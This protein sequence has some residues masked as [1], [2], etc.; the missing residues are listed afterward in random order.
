MNPI[1]LYSNQ[2]W[3]D[4]KLIKMNFDNQEFQ[5]FISYKYVIHLIQ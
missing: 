3:K 2:F 5:Y 1:Y 4:K